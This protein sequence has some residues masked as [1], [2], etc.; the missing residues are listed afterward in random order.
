MAND[1]KKKVAKVT[2]KSDDL[3][4]YQDLTIRFGELVLK[5]RF[6][7]FLWATY[8]CGN[9][10]GPTPKAMKELFSHEN[11]PV[12]MKKARKE[13]FDEKIYKKKLDTLNYA[14]RRRILPD[15][16]KE[17]DPTVLDYMVCIAEDIIL[18]E[19]FIADAGLRV[20]NE[21]MDE[22]EVA[23]TPDM[24]ESSY[25]RMEDIFTCI[26]KMNIELGLSN[27][28]G[29][30][31]EVLQEINEYQEKN[32]GFANKD[33]YDPALNYRNAFSN[34]LHTFAL[35]RHNV[36]LLNDSEM[37]EI[38]E[39]RGGVSDL[40]CIPPENEDNDNFSLI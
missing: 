3:K 31:I 18:A 5:N 27:D 20:F 35:Y 9:L 19:G 37:K 11:N 12:G 32:F 21:F 25:K 39:K 1:K 17:E 14:P 36:M 26:R 6:F 28:T 24:E 38:L 29:D 23:T 30:L 34:I 10:D 22:M 40:K 15:I 8:T 13:K 2:V 16:A 33:T 4:H 7:D